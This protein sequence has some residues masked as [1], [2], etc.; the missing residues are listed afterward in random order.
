MKFRDLMLAFPD[1]QFY[2]PSPDLA[3]WHVQARVADTLVNF[4][5]HKLVA[6][7]DGDKKKYEG[8]H[9][10]RRLIEEHLHPFDLVIPFHEGD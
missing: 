3:P 4:Y 5:P 9:A 1:I 6:Y 8:F 2:K 10:I 7:V